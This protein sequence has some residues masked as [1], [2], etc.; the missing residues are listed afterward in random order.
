MLLL[1][2]N[3]FNDFSIHGARVNELRLSL[4]MAR[5]ATQ[6]SNATWKFV[7]VGGMSSNG[8][9]VHSYSHLVRIVVYANGCLAWTAQLSRQWPFRTVVPTWF[10]RTHTHV[11][12]WSF[13]H[14]WQMVLIITQ[15]FVDRL[16]WA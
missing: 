8:I 16:L 5:S 1:P 6:T 4:R 7:V 10:L 9:A 14:T 15:Q 2:F 11:C 13:S 3:N 12:G